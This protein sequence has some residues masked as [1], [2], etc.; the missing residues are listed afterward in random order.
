MTKDK[1]FNLRK[2][3]KKEVKDKEKRDQ[4]WGIDATLIELLSPVKNETSPSV[5]DIFNMMSR[6][7]K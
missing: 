4:E 5:I 3:I 1:N 2:H 7:K 6:R